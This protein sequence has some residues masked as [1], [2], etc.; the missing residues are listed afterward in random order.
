MN[1]KLA[2]AAALAATLVCA[3]GAPAF[4]HHAVN[5]QYDT[6][7]D[8]EMTAVLERL[9]DVSPHNLWHVVVKNSSGVAEQWVLEGQGP[10]VLRRMGI[11]VKEDIKAGTT[12]GF[13]FSPAFSN[14]RIGYIKAIIINGKKYQIQQL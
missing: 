6:S 3:A 1:T 5:A 11:K 14:A 9:E 8:V 10:N 7:K 2:V 13:V 4:A 12:Y